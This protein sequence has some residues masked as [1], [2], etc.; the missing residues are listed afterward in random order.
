MQAQPLFC[1]AANKVFIHV[2]ALRASV[3]FF[4]AVLVARWFA[5]SGLQVLGRGLVM[6]EPLRD[7]GLGVCQP[8][9]ATALTD[10]RMMSAIHCSVLRLA[11][12]SVRLR[13]PLPAPTQRKPS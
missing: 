13:E 10:T 1:G 6:A 5:S 8:N 9:A 2:V 7:D 12:M 4:L 11:Q 3:C